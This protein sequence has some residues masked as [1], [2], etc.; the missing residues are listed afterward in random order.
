MVLDYFTKHK[1]GKQPAP[2]IT[3]TPPA[4][5][6]VEEESK[7]S[8]HTKEVEDFFRRIIAE[9]HQSPSGGQVVIFDKKDEGVSADAET[10]LMGGAD[11]VPLPTSPP[12]VANPLEAG[13]SPSTE[14]TTDAV[15]PKESR[16]KSYLSYIHKRVPAFPFGK[17][18]ARKQ[19]G[20]DLADV[21]GAVK[22]GESLA[23]LT[24]AEEAE[25]EK[26]ELSDVLDQL[27]LS[28]VNNRAFSFSDESQN[29][30]QSSHRFLKISSTEFQRHM[31][32]SRNCW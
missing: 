10:K 11:K 13:R 18:A 20:S 9:D 28:A 3:T 5:S 32:I 24:A 21:A 2:T 12:A 17:D 15:R 1:K 25:K 22:T 29:S 30:W 31:M 19:A 8:A 6:K 23:P 26:K 7:S 4:A 16:R 14:E 27:N